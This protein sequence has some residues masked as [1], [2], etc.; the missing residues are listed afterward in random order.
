M[1]YS[2]GEKN[3]NIYII[4]GGQVQLKGKV[5]QHARRSITDFLF[6][7][8][9]N[10]VG[11]VIVGP[12]ET[13]GDEVLTGMDSKDYTATA[14]KR[15]LCVFISK[16]DHDALHQRSIDTNEDDKFRTLLLI[17]KKDRT[18]DQILALETAVC[19]FPFFK[20]MKNDLRAELCHSIDFVELQDRHIIFNQGDEGDC[21]YI[22]LKGSVEIYIGDMPVVGDKS[23]NN[24]NIKPVVTLGPGAQFGELSLIENQPRA[25]AAIT[26][27]RTE[28]ALL[29]KGAYQ[30]T[31][32]R[33]HMNH[34]KTR[35]DF[36]GTL[37]IFKHLRQSILF[38]HSYFFTGI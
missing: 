7:P 9:V 16:E 18:Q 27:G 31:L 4:L 30:R 35:V 23:S 36:L 29:T 37:N 34:L 1:V 22:V 38:K 5:N 13:F 28:L 21:F 10:G 14:Q 12:G 25:G 26:S 3:T 24:H 19:Q 8:D 11:E 32:K 33:Q 17:P 6:K 20:K 15:T 2:R